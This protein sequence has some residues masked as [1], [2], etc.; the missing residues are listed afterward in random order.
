ML[1]VHLQHFQNLY[2]SEIRGGGNYCC[3]DIS[4]KNVS[5]GAN[6]TDLDVTAC[7]SECEPYF[8]MHFEVCFSD[9][10]CS[11][12]KNETAVIDNI[13]ST[14]ISPLLVQL[15][16]NESMI[17]KTMID[18][19]VNVSANIKKAST[20]QLIFVYMINCLPGITQLPFRQHCMWMYGIVQQTREV[21]TFI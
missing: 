20:I 14:C 18:D 19:I 9:G 8:E 11:N 13:L 16:S 4:Y 1:C 17:G 21:T 15:Q 5:C 10:T 2:N 6:L 12:M 3:C 7:T